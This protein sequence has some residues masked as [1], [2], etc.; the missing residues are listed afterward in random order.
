MLITYILRGTGGLLYWI[1]NIESI[2]IAEDEAGSRGFALRSDGVFN[3]F[4]ACE[5]KD[6]WKGFLGRI[7]SMLIWQSSQSLAYTLSWK[8]AGWPPMCPHSDDDP[9]GNLPRF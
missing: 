7:H 8:S 6:S 3:L 5:K 2:G 4:I 9:H 1:A